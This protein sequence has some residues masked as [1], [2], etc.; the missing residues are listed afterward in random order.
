MSVRVESACERSNTGNDP[1]GRVR[2]RPSPAAPGGRGQETLPEAPAES[3][4]GSA[5]GC[6]ARGWSACS[7]QHERRTLVRARCGPC[8]RANAER[9][10]QRQ[11][12]AHRLR[13]ETALL[14]EPEAEIVDAQRIDV[15]DRGTVPPAERG[16][17][18]AP[19]L[20][21]GIGAD[22][23]G[24]AALGL[25]EPIGDGG[26]KLPGARTRQPRPADRCRDRPPRGS[27]RARVCAILD[28]R[29][30]RAG[31]AARLN[32]GAEVDAPADASF[33]VAALRI[34][35]PDASELARHWP[36]QIAGLHPGANGLAVGGLGDLLPRCYPS[37]S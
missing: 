6:A 23:C 7:R 15:G 34:P 11:A 13:G 29:A 35:W 22:T 24:V 37:I 25:S 18:A 10:G 12:R 8:A 5:P 3:R 17:H 36:E 33:S 16:S 4:P 14:G 19:E 26:P 1:I 2:P 20:V 9:L 32:Q 27:R 31:Q 28:L 30:A 21:E